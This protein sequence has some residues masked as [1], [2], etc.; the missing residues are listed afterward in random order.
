[1]AGPREPREV[2]RGLWERIQARDWDG[3]GDLL[4]EDVVFEWPQTGE[5][6]V[7]RT[8]VIGMNRAYPEGW[9]IELGRIVA[10]GDLVVSEVRVPHETLGVSHAASFFEVRDGRIARAVEYWV[11]EGEQP[12]PDWRAPFRETP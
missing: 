8:N 3:A 6:F 1:M 12:P 4:H 11:D 9:T 7:G 2:V 5:R 10:E